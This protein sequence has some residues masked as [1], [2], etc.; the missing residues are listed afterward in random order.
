MSWWQWVALYCAGVLAVGAAYVL[1]VLHT[2]D[3][4]AAEEEAERQRRV[5][6]I[7]D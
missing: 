1:D 4:E 2:L 3:Q 6:A 5:R 7:L